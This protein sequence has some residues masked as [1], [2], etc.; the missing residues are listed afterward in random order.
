MLIEND[1]HSHESGYEPYCMQCRTMSRMKRTDYGWKCIG[2][3]G[4]EIDK[5]KVRRAES[6]L[7]DP[8]ICYRLNHLY[9]DLVYFDTEGK[10]KR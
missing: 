2:Y 1:P 9:G 4:N 8:S 7:N 5:N 6:P 3:C 10:P